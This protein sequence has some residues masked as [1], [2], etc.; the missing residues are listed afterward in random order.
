MKGDDARENG[1]DAFWREQ[2]ALLLETLETLEQGAYLTIIS[3]LRHD[4]CQARSLPCAFANG[5]DILS[6]PFASECTQ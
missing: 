3:Y 5:D 4:S 6:P 1:T 2:P